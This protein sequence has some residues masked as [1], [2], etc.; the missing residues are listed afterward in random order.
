MPSMP[1]QPKLLERIETLIRT[2]GS[3]QSE[4]A[5]RLCVSR[6][7]VN[8]VLKTKASVTPRIAALL[9]SALDNLD[10]PTPALDA[11]EIGQ[12]E[13]EVSRLAL[14]VAQF[15]TDCV[16]QRVSPTHRTGE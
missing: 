8:N 13:Q 3:N 2:C 9:Q 16:E 6:G 7:L 4:A 5:R 14:M 11:Y 1:E 10:G 15:I 12:S